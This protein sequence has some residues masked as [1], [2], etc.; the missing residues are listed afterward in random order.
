MQR[1]GAHFIYCNPGC[2]VAKGVIEINEK[3]IVS[4]LFS[5]N[6]F[7]EELHTTVFYNGIL[8]PPLFENLD[9]MDF[10]GQLVFSVLDKLYDAH[11]FPL[12]EGIIAQLYLLEGLDLIEKRILP[13]TSLLKLF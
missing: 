2:I 13:E 6:D 7:P 3:G 8:L 12:E 9:L 10:R 11:P 1:F 4:R 5:L